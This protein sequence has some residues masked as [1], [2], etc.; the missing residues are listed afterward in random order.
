VRDPPVPDAEQVPGRP[1]GR[2][3][4]VAHHRVGHEARGLPVDEHHR[5]ALVALALQVP[6]VGVVGGEDQPVHAASGERIHQPALALGVVVEAGR[7]HRRLALGR[8]HLD[9]SVD[10]RREGIVDRVQQQADGQRPAVAAAQRTGSLVRLEV[11][12]ADGPLDTLTG[13]G[14]HV[15]LVVDDARYRL[16]TD[17]GQGGDVPDGGAGPRAGCGSRS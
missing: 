1:R 10:A 14:R 17:L 2:L 12:R 3:V 11:E 8:D 16:D 6:D 13:L 5:G 9:G 7:E 15:R 4:V